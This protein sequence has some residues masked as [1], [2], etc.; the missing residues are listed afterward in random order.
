MQLRGSFTSRRYGIRNSMFTI[1]PAPWI[2]PR[3]FSV[4]DQSDI[5]CQFYLQRRLPAGAFDWSTGRDVHEGYGR[6][7]LDPVV[8]TEVLPLLRERL[9]PHLWWRFGALPG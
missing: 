6:A 9:E 3:T 4:C 2:A 7:Q 8:L 1:T 5:V